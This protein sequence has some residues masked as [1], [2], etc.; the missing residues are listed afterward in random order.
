MA[1]ELIT[2]L[3]FGPVDEDRLAL[4]D[5]RHDREVVTT[6]QAT[7]IVTTGAVEDE[8]VEREYI[9]EAEFYPGEYGLVNESFDKYLATFEE[10]QVTQEAMTT[11]VY[12]D[13]KSALRLDDVFVEVHQM[14]PIEKRTHVGKP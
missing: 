2:T 5:L 1:K 13:L 3:D 11:K 4:V 9:V 12:E 8:N 14:E 7:G 6:I 10:A